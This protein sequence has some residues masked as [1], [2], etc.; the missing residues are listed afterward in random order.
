MLATLHHLAV[1]A[2]RER[3]R[4]PVPGA[5]GKHAPHWESLSP[6]ASGS[7]IDFVLPIAWRFPKGSRIGRM[8]LEI[9]S[10]DNLVGTPVSYA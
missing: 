5:G 3:F 7:R 9:K 10:V 1:I 6:V 4:F 2:S 8:A